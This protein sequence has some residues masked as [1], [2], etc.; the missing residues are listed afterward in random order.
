MKVLVTGG[1]G[2]IGSHMVAMLLDAGHDVITLDNLSTGYRDA[3]LGGHFVKG[4]ISDRQQLRALLLN[5]G[6]EIVMHFAS[7]IE[8]GESVIA[9]GKYYRNNVANTINLLDAMLEAGVRRIVYS[10][11]AAVYGEPGYVPIDEIHPVKPLNPYGRSKSCVES[12]LTDYDTAH[13]LRYV[14]LR[15]FNAA[16]A[17]PGGRLGERH[18]PESHLIPRLLQAAMRSGAGFIVN[19]SD[20]PTK[21][22][23]CIRDFIHVCDLCDAHMLAV[24]RLMDGGHSETYNV[25]SGAG[26]SVLDVI[27][28]ARKIVGRDIQVE[29]GPRRKGDPAVLVANPEKLVKQLGWRPR[30]PSIERMVEHAWE[31]ELQR[32]NG[33]PR[34]PHSPKLGGH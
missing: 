8:V 12:I 25:G 1:A 2:Y 28:A 11:S 27:E 7:S 33:M 5:A 26:Y 20:Y 23:T 14:S 13:G 24:Q 17:D 16:G 32:A 19:G 31:W 4:D 15:Y 10:S 3:V 18:V 30:F 6:I 21:D 9:P 34:V 29:F 22:G